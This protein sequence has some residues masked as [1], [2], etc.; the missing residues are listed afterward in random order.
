MYMEDQN[1]IRKHRC[2]ALTLYVPRMPPYIPG[3]SKDARYLPSKT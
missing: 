3:T 1:W 2:V